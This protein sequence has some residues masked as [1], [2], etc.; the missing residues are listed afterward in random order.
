MNPTLNLEVDFKILAS[1]ESVKLSPISSQIEKSAL[2]AQAIQED[3]DIAF[4]HICKLYGVP[5]NISEDLKLACLLKVREISNGGDCHLKYKCPKC[6]RVTESVI[7]L[8]DML[9]FSLFD[10]IER[11]RDAK[12]KDL[13]DLNLDLENIENV[14]MSEVFDYFEERPQLQNLE[15][16]KDLTLSLK[17]R[18]PK[19]K[20]DMHSRCVLCGFE[21]LVNVDRQFVIKSLSTHS[22]A[23]MY[24]VYHKLVINGF[25]KLDVDS[26]LPFEREIQSGLI[27]QAVQNLKNAREG[28]QTQSA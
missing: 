19:F 18:F 9:D 11:F 10:K 7:M 14:K 1:G 24:Q 16:V 23:A 2:E 15:D 5:E 27:D 28:K 17:A 3:E 20:H 12:L 13:G 6:K 26:M 4:T 22:I 21:N 25:T 8:E